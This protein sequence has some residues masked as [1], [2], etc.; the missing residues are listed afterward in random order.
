MKKHNTFVGVDGSKL[1][2]DICTILQD[3]NMKSE[4][5]ENNNKG[6]KLLLKWLGDHENVF[7]CLEHTGVY[8]IPLCMFLE[9]HQITYCL[10][11]AIVIKKSLGLQRGKSDRADAKAIARYA[12]LFYDEL[13]PFSLPQATLM[14]LKFCW[15]NVSSSSEPS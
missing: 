4:S 1:R 5:F 14:Q 6:F 8:A 10:V 12:A 3:Q 2:I 11:P 15:L 7:V 9:E 13:K